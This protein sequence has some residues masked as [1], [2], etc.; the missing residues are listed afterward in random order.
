M[1]FQQMDF[2]LQQKRVD[3]IKKK[4]GKSERDRMNLAKAEEELE[5]AREV[6]LMGTSRIQ[7]RNLC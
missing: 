5:N 3:S 2:D 7:Q 1:R 6:C 4:K